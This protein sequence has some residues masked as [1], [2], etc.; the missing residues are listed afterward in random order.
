MVFF[1]VVDIQ[2]FQEFDIDDR[3]IAVLDVGT[4]VE[5]GER[6]ADL[7]FWDFM[8]L[9]QDAVEVGAALLGF[10]QS[11]VQFGLSDAVVGEQ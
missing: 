8:F 2:I 5:L 4:F 3:A 7:Q 1:E 6:F 10:G 11:I 9:D